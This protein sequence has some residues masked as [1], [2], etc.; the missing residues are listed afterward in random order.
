MMKD[1][2][3]IV[4]PEFEKLVEKDFTRIPRLFMWVYTWAS[5][6]LRRYDDA[7]LKA[8]I[9]ATWGWDKREGWVS[10]NLIVRYT[11]ILPQHIYRSIDKLI[12]YRMITKKNDEYGRVF[13][14]IECDYTQ[15]QIETK[16]GYIDFGKM[17]MRKLYPTEAESAH[18]K[19][20]DRWNN[21]DEID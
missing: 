21:S 5:R 7:V 12:L 17:K 15:W 19:E 10:T 6:Y 4:D 20:L 2:K 13:L 11:G 3:K 14:R 1:K 18:Y 9:C 8:I 16:T